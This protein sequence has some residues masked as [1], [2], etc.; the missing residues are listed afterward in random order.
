MS[1]STIA[2]GDPALAVAETHIARGWLWHEYIRAGTYPLWTDL[3]YGGFPG[4]QHSPPLSHLLQALIGFL[5]FDP[6]TAAKVLT[7]LC[8]MAGGVGFA[9]FCARIHR[10]QRSGLLGGII[11]ALAP[12]F[13]SVWVWE[14][15]LPGAVVLAILPWALIAGERLSSGPCFSSSRAS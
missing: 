11:Y 9:I 5:R 3:W 13:H 12:A 10:D 7:W 6:Y 15:H 8:R 14:G 4:A 1:V 2:R